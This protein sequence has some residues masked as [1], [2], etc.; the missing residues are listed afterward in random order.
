MQS[1]EDLIANLPND[2]KV[3]VIRLRN[4]ILGA[5]PRIQ[6]KL[7]YG[8]PYFFHNRR[9]CFLWPVSALPCGYDKVQYNDEKVSFGFCYGNLLSNDQRV[10]QLEKRKQVA[11]IKF[12][13]TR[14]IDDRV[15]REIMQEAILIDDNFGKNK[16][17]K[18]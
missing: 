6:E 5:D 9:I 4:L 10:L 12:S 11:V 13:S 15:I 7:A 16:K 17:T 14:Q 2:E 1:V 8:V 3:I 18:H